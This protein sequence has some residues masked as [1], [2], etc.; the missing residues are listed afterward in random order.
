MNGRT[1]GFCAVGYGLSILL[2]A[3]LNAIHP[4]EAIEPYG[5]RLG[6][7]QEQAIAV[8]WLAFPQSYGAMINL[9]GYPDARDRRSDWY[10]LPR[11]TWLIIEYRGH[12]AIGYRWQN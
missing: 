1:P 7:T 12:Q 6:I 4:A 10:R 3:G 11:D 2:S 5:D 9:L 8:A